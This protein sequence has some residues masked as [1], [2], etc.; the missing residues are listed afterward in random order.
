MDTL[1]SWWFTLQQRDKKR[2]RMNKDKTKK[3]FKKIKL[4]ILDV[5]GVLTKGEIIYD[6]RGRELKVFNV[7][8]GLG[9]FLLNKL[10]IKTILLTAKDGKVVR[11]RAQDCMIEEVIGGVLPKESVLDGLCKKYKV[12]KEEVCFM[13]DD[14]IDVELIKKV[15]VGVAVRDAQAKVKKAA[16]YIT[17]KKG[18]EGAVRE[19][20]DLIIKH[21]NLEAEAYKFIKK[22][23]L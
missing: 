23:L 19:V 16:C 22:P 9:V 10:G 3:L 20:V 1:K 11:R 4:L 15:G 14:L 21:K 12:K 6:D 5:D 7:K 17:V 13:G 2:K 8:D 18:G